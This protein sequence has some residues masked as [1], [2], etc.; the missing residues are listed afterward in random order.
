MLDF[1]GC[2]TTVQYTLTGLSETSIED[3]SIYPNPTS[4]AI[5]IDL[6]GSSN[7]NKIEGLQMVS[8]NGQ[9]LK[10]YGKNN[11]IIDISA[12]SEGLYVLQI[13]L[14]SGE[15]INKRVLILR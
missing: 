1:D 12:L 3:I 10:V 9:V 8:M 15:Q 4:T 6:S 7:D 11:R 14:S 2:E 5:Y 13:N